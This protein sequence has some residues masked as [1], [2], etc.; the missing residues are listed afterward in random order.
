MALDQDYFDLIH[1]EVVKKKYY[2]ANKVEAVFADIRRQAQELTEENAA[3]RRAQRAEQPPGLAW[4]GRLLRA[5]GLP[6]HHRKS[7]PPG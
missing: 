5:G 7:Q 4:R 3:L 1:I 6:P 2:N